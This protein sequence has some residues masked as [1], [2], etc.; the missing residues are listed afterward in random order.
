[1]TDQGSLPAEMRAWR[2]HDWGSDPI[3]TLQLDRV[4]VPRPESGE[5]LV[6]VQVVP[7]N[8]NDLERINGKNMM[9]R[10]EL[11]VTPGM[12]VMGMVAAA[13]E[14]VEDWIGRRVVAMPKQA[15][16]GFAEYAICPVVSAFEMPEDISLPGAAALYFPYHLAWLGAGRSRGPR[17]RRECLDPCG[18]GRGRVSCDSTRQESGGEG[19]CNCGK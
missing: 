15:T 2:V 13:G 4:R 18:C 9:V 7:L 8:I 19:L 16:G 12:E 14:G 3:E 6:R 5:L 11:P 17:A 10:P 1:M